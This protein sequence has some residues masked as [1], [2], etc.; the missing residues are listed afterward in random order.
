MDSALSLSLSLLREHQLLL[1]PSL[2]SLA[3]NHEEAVGHSNE[4]CPLS[5]EKRAHT[6][7]QR[8]FMAPQVGVGDQGAWQG[9]A[10]AGQS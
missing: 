6:L 5:H 1:L 3:S 2:P 8:W 9:E 4:L 10:G 7:E